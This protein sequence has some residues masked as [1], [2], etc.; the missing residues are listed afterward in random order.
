MPS[1]AKS[2]VRMI[3]SFSSA[4]FASL[5]LQMFGIWHIIQ[6][7]WIVV[8]KYR[9]YSLSL[10]LAVTTLLGSV[11]TDVIWARSECFLAAFF[12]AWGYWRVSALELVPCASSGA[13]HIHIIFSFISRTSWWEPHTKFDSNLVTYSGFSGLNNSGGLAH[14]LLGLLDTHPMV[15][16]SSSSVW[17][18]APYAKVQNSEVLG[19]PRR[20]R[21]PEFLATCWTR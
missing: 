4:R 1:G 2:E 11:S 3:T 21:R 5:V 15:I 10:R 12:H 17:R 7:L 6:C 20:F 8:W 13:F 9:S 18:V 19:V 14:T 16:N